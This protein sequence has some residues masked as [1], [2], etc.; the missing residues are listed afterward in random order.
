MSVLHDMK[1]REQLNSMGSGCNLRKEAYFSSIRAKELQFLPSRSAMY[2][3]A[4]KGS[5]IF[6]VDDNNLKFFNGDEWIPL[7]I[8]SSFSNRSLN[9]T[10]PANIAPHF[11]DEEFKLVN[12]IRPDSFA[13]FC[14]TPGESEIIVTIPRGNCMLPVIDKRNNTLLGDMAYDLSVS[15]GIDNT[16]IGTRSGKHTSLGGGNTAIG[17]MSFNANE[18]GDKNVAIGYKSLSSSSESDGN[19]AIGYQS[20]KNLEDGCNVAIGCQ[21]QSKGANGDRN[22]SVGTMSLMGN[23][24]SNNTAIG[25]ESGLDSTGNNNILI[26]SNASSNVFDDCIVIGTNSKATTSGQ[27]VIGGSRIS[28]FIKLDKGTGIVLNSA[29]TSESRIFLTV[30]SPAGVMGMCYVAGRIPGTGFTVSSTSFKDSSI[31]AWFMFDS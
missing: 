1:V 16:F 19:V 21:S 3:F 15:E 7:C 2:A 5:I 18:S 14:V 9:P 23:D 26:G 25:H 30:Q 8:S 22:T 12:S 31:I 11:I 27:L 28:G 24:G 29:V 10:T 17:S 6:D 20:L 13:R 4:K